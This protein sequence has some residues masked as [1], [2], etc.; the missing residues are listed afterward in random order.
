MVD[1]DAELVEHEFARRARA[2]AVDADGSRRRSAPTRRWC[3]PRPTAPARR[4]AGSRA[5]NA[6]SC[7][8]KRSQLGKL[9]AR[10]AMPR[11]LQRCGG[12]DA[13]LDLAAGADEDHLRARR[14]RVTMPAPRSTAEPSVVTGMSWRLSTSA[15]GPSWS[16]A[17]TQACDRLV[18]RRPDGSPAGRGSPAAWRAAR[19]AGGSGRPRRR[20][21]E[22][23]VK[24]KHDLGVRLSAASR[25]GGS[26][27]VEE[28]EERAADR[29]DAAVA[30]P[31][32]PLPSPM[33]CSRM[34]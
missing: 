10:A 11:S 31:C 18:A 30:A 14:S 20:P 26:H 28:H 17:S 12:V 23:W 7:S 27:V 24:T 16:T 19:R 9:T 33:A 34:P 2:E 5:R 8:A 3:R 15:V 25:I 22:S 1:V 6:S 21:T 32:R 29:Q 13:H 4:A